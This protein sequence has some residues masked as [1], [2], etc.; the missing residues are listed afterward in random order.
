MAKGVKSS[1][2]RDL[3]LLLDFNGDARRGTPQEAMRCVRDAI[4]R[5]VPAAIAIFKASDPETYSDK[6]GKF[7]RGLTGPN[8]CEVFF[9]LVPA[10]DGA[11]Q[12]F[13]EEIMNYFQQ[14]GPHSIDALLTYD[15]TAYNLSKIVKGRLNN[16]LGHVEL[17]DTCKVVAHHNTR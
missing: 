3:A 13:K 17:P 5:A 15:S 9:D 1:T 16:I 6:Q 12:T 11:R 2:S 14:D 8:F 10:T 7:P 4:G